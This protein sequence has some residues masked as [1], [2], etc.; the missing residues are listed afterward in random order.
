MVQP[1]ER[2]REMIPDFKDFLDAL[3][4]P[5]PIFVRVNTLKIGPETFKTLMSN[6]GYRME[7]VDHLEGAFRLREVEKPGSTLE[8]LLGYFHVQGLTSMLPARI[9]AP[10]PEEIILDLC[11]APGGKVTQM[12][13]LMGGRGLLVANDRRIDRIRILRSNIDRLGATCL[14]VTRYSGQNFPTRIKFDR[15]LLDPPCSAEGT[16][17][18]VSGNLPGED[19]GATDRLAVLQK[20]LLRRAMEILKPGGTLVYSTCTY[21]PE[22][23]EAVISDILREGRA[24]L[25]PIS[26][27][28]PHSPGL[29]S[30]KGRVFHPRIADAVRLYP[31]QI[32]SWGF[33]IAHLRKRG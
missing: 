25:L 3:R 11:S 1:F 13:Q 21:S 7:P 18:L 15:I 12:A 14:L 2:Y 8:Y 27:P 23:N 4:Q 19:P 10:E 31:H 28:F 26:I 33:F 16:R 32:N 20:A 29:N 17:R 9:L 6:R 24:E 5:P 22:E 30:W